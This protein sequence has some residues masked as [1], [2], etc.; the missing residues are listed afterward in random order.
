MKKHETL[1]PQPEG[2]CFLCA[3]LGEYKYHSIRERHHIFYGSNHAQAEKY[4]FTIYLCRHHHR[5][6]EKGDKDA[7]HQPDRNDFD[8]FLKRW[9]QKKYEETHTRAEFM[10]IFGRS[11]L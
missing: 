6:D 4:G 8:D 3:I 9:A 2:E 10:N 5:G 7:V 11:W 1:F